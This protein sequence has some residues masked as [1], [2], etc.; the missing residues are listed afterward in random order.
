VRIKKVL[1]TEKRRSSFYTETAFCVVS[2]NTPDG[3]SA[4]EKVGVHPILVWWR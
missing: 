4:A 1:K 3:K 2:E